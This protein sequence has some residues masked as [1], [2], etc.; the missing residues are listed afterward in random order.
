MQKEES[1][2]EEYDEEAFYKKLAEDE[3]RQRAFIE[4]DDALNKRLKELLERSQK[5]R[6]EI[7]ESQ[8]DITKSENVLN[9]EMDRITTN[10][11]MKVAGAVANM[12]AH[13]VDGQFVEDL[14]AGKHHKPHM[15]H[16]ML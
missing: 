9:K 2:Y 15:K 5:A 7:A 11:N 16:R 8:K 10:C 13:G 3:A 6:A 4:A 14:C 1:K 12:Y